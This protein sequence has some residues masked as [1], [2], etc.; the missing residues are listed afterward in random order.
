[1]TIQ[2]DVYEAVEKR[3]YRGEWTA[4]QFIARNI[5]K[6]GEELAEASECVSSGA[7]LDLITPPEV[8]KDVFDDD[9]PWEYVEIDNLY[10]LKKELSDVAVVLFCL[11]EVVNEIDGGNFD[12]VKAALTKAQQDVKRGVRK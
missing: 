9:A 6:L 3:G 7:L 2:S 11:S 8:W 5:A 12:V 4:E 1:M 10:K